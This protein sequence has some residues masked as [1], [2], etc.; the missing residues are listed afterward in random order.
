VPELKGLKQT[1]DLDIFFPGGPAS[2]QYA[3]YTDELKKDLQQFATEVKT[4]CT[5][6]ATWVER[7]TKL[8]RLASRTSYAR[9]FISCHG[10]ADVANQ[11]A[12]QLEGQNRQMGALLGTINTLI[13]DQMLS[14]PQE[15]WVSLL[16]TPE[17]AD[18]AWNLEER[19]N[20]A[21]DMLPAAQEALVNTLSVNG[22]HGWNTL[23][24]QITG[25][26]KITVE[27]EGVTSIISPGQ[28]QNRLSHTDPVRRAYYMD[29]WDKAWDEAADTIAVGLN[30]MAGYRLNLY[31]ARG[32][33]D[34]LFEPMRMNRMKRTTLES[35]YTA[36]TQNRPRLVAFLQ[37]KKELLGLSSLGWQDVD[38]P[39]SGNEVKLTYDEAANFIVTH[40][41]RLSPRMAELAVRAFQ[42]RWIESEDRSGKRMGGFCSGFPEAQQSRIFVTFSGSKGNV[43]TLA[44][45]LGHAYHSWVLKDL[46]Q[47]T[48]G[49]AMNVAE[50]ASTFAEVLVGDAAI[51]AAAN[52]A[53]R[54]SLMEDKLRRGVGQMTNLVCRFVFEKA[55]YEERQKGDLSVARLNELMLAAQKE[56]Y[57]NALDRWHPTFWA[58]K[59]HFHNTGTPFY[60]FPYTFGYLFATGIYAHAV[61]A[62][63]EFEDKYAALLRDTGRS[64]VEDLAAKH[65]GVDLSQP[66]FWLSAID[67]ALAE[68][69]EWLELTQK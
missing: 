15:E 69:A 58:S 14:L 18:L 10:A 23:Y 17:L 6:V 30:Q 55:F 54:T 26:I 3:A 11:A 27:E 39:L 38:A 24:N 62:G 35:M 64:T 51:A 7:L 13:N 33:E 50:T 56:S 21:K 42:E 47:M 37:R 28:L 34:F 12:R 67:L 49:Y 45:E 2:P 53:E 43:A 48:K 46:P 5:E 40:F 20:R 1:W 63:P 57:G 32:W 60:N 22:Y 41:N 59:L 19:R 68:L 61:Q 9:A 52:Q 36:I 16:A 29:L 8:Q 44:H 25:S 4:P 66:D 31:R 65:L